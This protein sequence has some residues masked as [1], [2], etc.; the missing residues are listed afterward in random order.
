M[1]LQCV[2]LTVEKLNG[3]KTELSNRTSDNADNGSLDKL[4]K[5]IIMLA[6]CLR[7]CKWEGSV[8]KA[9]G[10]RENSLLI[11]VLNTLTLSNKLSAFYWQSLL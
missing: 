2:F 3:L 6:R 8:F 4:R 11:S 5:P 9:N 1:F 7:R 10:H